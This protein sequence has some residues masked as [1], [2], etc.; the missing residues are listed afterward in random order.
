VTFQTGRSYPSLKK[1]FFG[2]R[3]GCVEK[4]RSRTELK[5]QERAMAEVRRYGVMNL[6]R[7]SQG[8]LTSFNVGVRSSISTRLTRLKPDAQAPDRTRDGMR[9]NVLGDDDTR[10]FML[11]IHSLIHLPGAHQSYYTTVTWFMS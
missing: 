1:Q 6:K 11:Y 8:K 5:P 2:K 9:L 3:N 7:K 10:N 4:R